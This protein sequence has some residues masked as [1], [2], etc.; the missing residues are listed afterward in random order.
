MSVCKHCGVAIR[1]VS[2]GWGH[3]DGIEFN[4]YRYCKMTFAASPDDERESKGS[5][6]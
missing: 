4:T 3:V 1:R 5:G 6:S 2:D